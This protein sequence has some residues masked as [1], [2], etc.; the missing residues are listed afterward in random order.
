M[1]FFPWHRYCVTFRDKLLVKDTEVRD[2]PQGMLEGRMTES[3]YT[4][5]GR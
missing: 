3:V 4:G 2:Y 5:E 1:S